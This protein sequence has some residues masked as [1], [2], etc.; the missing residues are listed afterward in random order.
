MIRPW[1]VLAVGDRA[2]SGIVSEE[3]GGAD[4]CPIHLRVF[5]PALFPQHDGQVRRYA[6]TI[7]RTIG[8]HRAVE[9]PVLGERGE[10]VAEG[11]VHALPAG[12]HEGVFGDRGDHL[13]VFCD[14]EI[15]AE[16]DIAVAQGPGVAPDESF[17]LL[18]RID[19]DGGEPPRELLDFRQIIGVARRKQGEPLDRAGPIRFQLFLF[20]NSGGFFEDALGFGAV[21]RGGCA[22][23]SQHRQL[24]GKLLDCT[25]A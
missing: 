14:K 12:Q 11:A 20:E 24:D 10:A 21:P 13:L 15:L 7:H 2:L 16:K 8:R 25:A 9:F 6:C 19:I 17:G 4:N 23:G 1:F 22:V 3:P 18:V 5:H